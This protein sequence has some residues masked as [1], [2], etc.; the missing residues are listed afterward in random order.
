MINSPSIRKILRKLSRTRFKE[1]YNFH[2][3]GFLKNWTEEQVILGPLI[4]H[5]LEN[6]T[7]HM[8]QSR[9]ENENS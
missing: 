4:E 1:L 6:M 5:I 3:I 7:F 9:N 8:D 2:E